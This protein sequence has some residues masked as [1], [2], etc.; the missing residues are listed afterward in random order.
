MLGKKGDGARRILVTFGTRPEA[1]A[2]VQDERPTSA[3]TPREAVLVDTVRALF[4][5]RRLTAAEFARAEAELG[6]PALIEVVTLAGYYGLVGL[7]LN[8]FEVELPR[9]DP[10]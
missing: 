8:A 1:I 4:R 6:R 2:V 9:S 10:G 5:T 7:I 3:L